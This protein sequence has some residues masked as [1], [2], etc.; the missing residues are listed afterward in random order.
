MRAQR[1]TAAFFNV[2]RAAAGPSAARSPRT[3]RVDG[4]NRVAVLSDGLWR[5][6]FGAD[7]GIVGKT[8]PLEGG[9]YE[10]LGV[11]PPEFEY[12][13]G[14]ARPTDSSCP[15]VVPPDER[16]RDPHRISI[17]LQSVARLKPGVTLAQAQAQDGSD[18]R[19]APAGE[20]GVEQGHARRR[21][22]R[23]TITSSARGRR[24]GC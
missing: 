19:G 7:P 20:S 15:Y 13:V 23:C 22:A 11:M 9:A 21:A 3:T 10:V 12:P 24:S 2:L 18:R 5:R 17:Y 8:I 1:V 14:A 6:R 4:Q 16:V